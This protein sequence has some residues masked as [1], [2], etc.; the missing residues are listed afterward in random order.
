MKCI[1]SIKFHYW[2]A[3]SG[4]TLVTG[5]CIIMGIPGHESLLDSLWQQFLRKVVEFPSQQQHTTA[6]A[7]HG[8]V[9]HRK[10]LFSSATLTSQQHME[11]RFIKRPYSILS[12]FQCPTSTQSRLWL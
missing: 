4:S 11:V 3:L 5:A 10:T 1:T 7:T 6:T 8:S 2:P 12:Q 9:F